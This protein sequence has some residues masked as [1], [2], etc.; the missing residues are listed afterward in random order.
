MHKQ[1]IVIMLVVGFLFSSSS[2]FAK[3]KKADPRVV[4]LK[5]LQEGPVNETPREFRIRMERVR[6]LSA[7]LSEDAQ[8]VGQKKMTSAQKKAEKIVAD[9][10]KKQ[11]KLSAKEDKS[12][13]SLQ[14]R[15]CDPG[16]VIVKP[17][18][19]TESALKPSSWENTL[20][21]LIINPYPDAIAEITSTKYGPLIENLCSGGRILLSFSVNGDGHDSLTGYDDILT[22][23]VQS[24]GAGV[25]SDSYHFNLPAT[26]GYNNRGTTPGVWTIQPRRQFSFFN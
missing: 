2:A 14:I 16:T 19:G 25:L 23:V 12:L 24:G 11:A 20:S 8:K 17:I 4:E 26:R 13:A 9:Q 1:F 10:D 5:S 15:G 7:E 6:I 21:L 18:V 3:D 22:A